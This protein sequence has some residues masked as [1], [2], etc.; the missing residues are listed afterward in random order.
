MVALNGLIQKEKG[1]ISSVV[2]RFLSANDKTPPSDT[3]RRFIECE[4]TSVND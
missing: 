4:D 3:G 2:K 1:P